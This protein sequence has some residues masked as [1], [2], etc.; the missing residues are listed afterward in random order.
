MAKKPY[1]ISTH[2]PWSGQRRLRV[3]F[4][5]A[6]P[7]CSAAAYA[8]TERGRHGLSAAT[9][10]QHAGRRLWAALQERVAR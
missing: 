8:V 7:G 3:Y 10:E 1:R 9:C 6:V 5:C 2:E 4:L